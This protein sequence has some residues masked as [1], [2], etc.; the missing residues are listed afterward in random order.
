MRHAIFHYITKSALAAGDVPR[1]EHDSFA[2]WTKLRPSFETMAS[3]LWDRSAEA[4]AN[5]A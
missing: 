1:V 5:K 4:A 2:V 3:Q